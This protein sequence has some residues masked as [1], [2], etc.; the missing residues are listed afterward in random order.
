MKARKSHVGRIFVICDRSCK[1]AV[2]EIRSLLGEFDKDLDTY[3]NEIKIDH[4]V[5]MH[6]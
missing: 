4:K 2:T 5:T 1:D 3:V 6:P